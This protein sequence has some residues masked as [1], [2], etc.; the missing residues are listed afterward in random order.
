[1]ERLNLLAL[2]VAVVALGLAAFAVASVVTEDDDA[3]SAAV[4]AASTPTPCQNF[5]QASAFLA[6]TLNGDAA[7]LATGQGS[8]RGDALRALFDKCV[9]FAR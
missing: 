1:M 6:G 7:V 3:S 8:D 5:Q 2:L 4:A 9:E